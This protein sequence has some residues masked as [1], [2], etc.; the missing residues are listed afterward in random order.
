LEKRKLFLNFANVCAR[1]GV[2]RDIV[3]QEASN[4]LFCRFEPNTKKKQKSHHSSI[5][6]W[7]SWGD[8]M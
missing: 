3:C 2:M 7:K 6:K 4:P 8:T 1:K 5:P